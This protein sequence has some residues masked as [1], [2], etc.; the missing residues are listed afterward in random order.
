M[1]DLLAGLDG[2]IFDSVPSPDPPRKRPTPTKTHQSPLRR[3]YKTPTKANH[4]KHAASPL[5]AL[6]ET[7]T[8][9]VSQLLQGAEDW[10][11]DDMNSDFLTPKKNASPK[12]RVRA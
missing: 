1:N 12:R 9:D 11:W 2:S 5:P 10:D 6:L 7:A 8:E 4:R 3:L